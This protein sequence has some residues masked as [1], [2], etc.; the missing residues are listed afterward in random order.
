M[1]SSPLGAPAPLLNESS[2][3]RHHVGG[4][5]IDCIHK[6][7]HCAR[8]A[9]ESEAKSKANVAMNIHDIVPKENRP[10]LGIIRSLAK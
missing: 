4:E 6:D 7:D 8:P 10:I 2:P 5:V 9:T 1:T 3:F